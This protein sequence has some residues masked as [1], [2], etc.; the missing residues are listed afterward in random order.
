MSKH[1]KTLTNDEQI[2]L[3]TYLEKPRLGNKYKA[4]E[5]RN[6]LMVLLMLDTGIRVGELVQLLF[7]DLFFN[8]E[9]VKALLIYAAIAKRNKERTIPLTERVIKAIWKY[10]QVSE[11]W[12][13][14]EPAEPAFNSVGTKRFISVRSVQLMVTAASM[15][16]FN[17]VVTP[18]QLRHTFATRLMSRTNIRVVQTLLGH[19]S[20]QSTQIYTHP[21]NDD[22]T[23]AIKSMEN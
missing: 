22:L 9:P 2:K 14:P 16:A 7:T 5:I 15:A 6:L 18:H 13:H 11:R 8:G 10:Y 4:W 17:R 21:N 3:I 1:I 23:N 12:Q 19:S 20:L